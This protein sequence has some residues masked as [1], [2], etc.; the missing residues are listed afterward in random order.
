MS[1][2]HTNN[3][4]KYEDE[5]DLRELIMAL[6][7][8]KY[9]IITIAIIAAIL[10]GLYSMFFISPVY[11][12]KL[13]IVVNMPEKYNTRYGEYI[14]PM[15]ANNQYINLITSNQVLL[16]TMEDIEYNGTVESLRNRISIKNS[17]SNEKQNNFTVIVS[18][19]NPQDSLKFAQALFENYYEFLD[20]MTKGRAI[21]YYYDKF[22]TELIVLEKSLES[23][24]VL[25]KKNEDLLAETA[26][27]INQ[28]DALQEVHENVHG[29][30]DYIVLGDIINPNYVEIEK[31]IITI[32]E[33]I[34]TIEDT[35]R[36]YNQ[37]LKTLEEQ[38]QVIADYYETGSY[39]KIANMDFDG[40]VKNSI[41]LP[42][43]PVAPN[44]K[45]SPSTTR[46][47]VIGLVIGLMLGLMTAYIK[48]FWVKG[49]RQ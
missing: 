34:F 14:L 17:D 36:Q 6:W 42:S 33:E 2:I 13:E 35:I 46:N 7:R 37:N 41:Y 16:N 23:K 1:D 15:T 32:Q 20:V 27:F 40:I 39:E 22:N 19:N 49:E 10:T 11:Q 47:V 26:K 31:N 24:H 12:T 3:I 28:K 25:L 8:N 43:Q 5:I 29:S 38:K 44:S 4:D 18:G 21:D 45:V 30:I 9:I 48:E